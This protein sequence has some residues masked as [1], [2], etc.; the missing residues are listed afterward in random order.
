VEVAAEEVWAALQLLGVEFVSLLG[1]EQTRFSLR[2]GSVDRRVEVV[3]AVEGIR[4]AR[5]GR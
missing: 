4:L 3:E 2:S 1:V 5:A